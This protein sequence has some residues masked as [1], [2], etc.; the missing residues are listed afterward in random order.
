MRYAWVAVYIA[1]DELIGADEV[2]TTC[3][4]RWSELGR[5]DM[6]GFLYRWSGSHALIR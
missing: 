3:M 6:L 1:A 5:R 2:E 4:L